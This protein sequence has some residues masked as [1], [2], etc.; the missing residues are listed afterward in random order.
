MSSVHRE[1]DRGSGRVDVLIKNAGITRDTTFK[2]MD[3]AAWDIVI[4]T[5]LH[6]VFSTL[7]PP[8]KREAIRIWPRITAVDITRHD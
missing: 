3:K 5:N 8:A 2:K 6:S 4:E 1:S 7:T